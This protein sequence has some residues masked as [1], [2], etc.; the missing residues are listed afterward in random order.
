MFDLACV[1]EKAVESGDRVECLKNRRDGI[2]YT[3]RGIALSGER[4]FYPWRR[5]GSKDRYNSHSSRVRN[6]RF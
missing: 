3:E 2:K 5:E 4:I 1:L 6:E